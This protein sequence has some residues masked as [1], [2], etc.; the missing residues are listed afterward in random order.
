MEFKEVIYGRRSVRAFLNEDVEEETILEILKDAIQ[1]PSAGNVQPWR[2]I[3]VRNQDTKF[4]LANA[5]LNQRFVAQAPWVVV[6][7]A[8]QDE[9]SVYYGERGRDLYCIQDT[10]AVAMT[11]LLSA[12][13]R[14]LGTC[15][16]GA[17]DEERVSEILKLRKGERA[18]A[19]IPIGKAA[20]ITTTKPRRKKLEEVVEIIY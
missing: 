5:A 2:F 18:V 20:K 12:Y 4:L 19:I 1:A 7:V 14:G 8:K 15:W 3:V 11:I 16:V 10:A 13:D 9:S 17:F 6:V